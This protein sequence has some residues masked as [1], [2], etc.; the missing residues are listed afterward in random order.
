MA[1]EN[2][3]TSGE[4]SGAPE[5]SKPARAYPAPAGLSV[6]ATP[7]GNAGD[8]TLRALDTLGRVAAVVCEDTRVTSKLFAIHAIRATLIAYHDHNA[9]R[10]RP[11]LVARLKAGEALALVS[12]A[13]TPLVS[14]PGYKLVGA[15]LDAGISVTALPGPSAIL[16]A[17]VLAG[18]PTDRFF[19]AGFLPPKQGARRAEIERLAPIPGSLVIYESPQ[20][21]AACLADLAELL[22]DRPAAVT[23]ELTKR[24]EE[25]RRGRLA[26]LARAYADAEPPKGEIVIVVGPSDNAAAVASDADIDALLRKALAGAS[27]RDAVDAV[28]AATGVKRRAVYQRALALGPV[29]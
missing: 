17:L 13:G 4:P 11:Q 28:A 8:I 20:R 10:V 18:L 23:R 7:I 15:C 14:D 1:V 24:F 27:L 9:E 12:D 26:A 21:L 6:V 16:A 22:G 25:V 2:G 29:P 19:F 3:A 5:A